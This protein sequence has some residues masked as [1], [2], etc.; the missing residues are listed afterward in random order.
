VVT[1]DPDTPIPTVTSRL[2]SED[3]GAAVVT[4]DDEPQGVVTDRKVALSLEE[5]PDISDR[6]A[7]EVMSEDIVAGEQDMSVYEALQQLSDENIRRLPIV[8]EDDTLVGIITLDDILVLL[9]E[10]LQDS[11]EIIKSQSPRL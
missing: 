7:E 10:E 2:K 6:T 5:M 1:V 9:G 3:V 8:D 4:E 11:T